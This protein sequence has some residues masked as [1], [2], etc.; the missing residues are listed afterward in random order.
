[1]TTIHIPALAAVVHEHHG[2]GEEALLAALYQRED[3]ISDA[4][5][6]LGAQF[7]LHP[8][9][10]AD[11]VTNVVALGSP[12]PQE[13]HQLIRAQFIALMERLAREQRGEGPGEEQS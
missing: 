3:A 5:R 11:V 9:I 4:L 1:M 2:S 7:G 6:A 10:V 12:V 8:E 13:T